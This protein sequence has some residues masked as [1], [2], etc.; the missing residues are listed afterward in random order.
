MPCV[1]V[2]RLGRFLGTLPIFAVVVIFRQVVAVVS[3]AIFILPLLVASH[4]R[5][6]VSQVRVST[7]GINAMVRKHG[8]Q[9]LLCCLQPPACSLPLATLKAMPC[10][11][12]AKAPNG[13]AR[14]SHSGRD[15]WLW[16]ARSHPGSRNFQALEPVRQY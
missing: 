1:L 4:G 2:S 7:L 16:R 13:W 10:G 14:G 3:H 9:V 6:N 5:N 12:L 15:G 8:P 11:L